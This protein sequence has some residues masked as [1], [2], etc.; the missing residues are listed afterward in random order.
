[1]ARG[2]WLEENPCPLRAAARALKD[3][4][5]ERNFNPVPTAALKH[6]GCPIGLAMR[7]KV[8]PIFG[9]LLI[10]AG[11]AACDWRKNRQTR[12]LHEAAT[13]INTELARIA[14]TIQGLRADTEAIFNRPSRYRNGL[15][16]NSRYSIYKSTV[17]YTPQDDGNCETWAS[18]FVPVGDEQK[19][20]IKALENICPPLKKSCSEN[21]LLAAVYFTTH[22]S[23]IIS[24]PFGDANSYL[25]PG[26]NATKAWVTYWKADE[27]H[28]PGRKTLWVEPYLD[29]M[30]RGYMVSVITPVYSG[31]RLEGTLG[32]DVTCDAMRD[33][34]FSG[35]DRNLMLITDR[36][37]LVAMSKPCSKLLNL[38]GP[39]NYD[40]LDKAAENRPI[41]AEF[42]LSKNRS[43]AIRLLA[44]KLIS[45]SEVFV[46]KI[47]GAEYRVAKIALTP[48]N[49][50]LVDLG[51]GK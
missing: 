16:Q 7:P 12:R 23:I 3:L 30:G 4:P 36:G 8:L 51:Q 28:N 42:D 14:D 20:K 21:R 39:G 35:E 18:G 49:W 32:I 2:I 50:Y 27:T 25:T 5:G 44:E 37:L 10:V 9:L 24:Y 22:D 33:R 26:L 11:I 46:I 13:A 41:S 31:D 38:S 45:V 19:L 48:V 29:A 15:Y 17:Y 1:M 47:G 6:P 40:Y 43:A 34:F